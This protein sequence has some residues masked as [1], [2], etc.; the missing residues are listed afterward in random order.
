MNG[1]SRTASPSLD[2]ALQGV[3][4]ARLMA[5]IRE[6]SLWIKLSATKD[7][8]ESFCYLEAQMQANGSRGG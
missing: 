1:N 8:F 3:D 5:H 2:Q 7:E 4:S 6:F